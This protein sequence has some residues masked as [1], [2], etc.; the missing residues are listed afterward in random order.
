MGATYPF[1]ETR[2]FDKLI[3]I[4]LLLLYINIHCDDINSFIFRIGDEE[5]Y[6]ISFMND[7]GSRKKVLGVGEG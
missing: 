3:M 6:E 5:K 1:V 4:F 7:K 2:K